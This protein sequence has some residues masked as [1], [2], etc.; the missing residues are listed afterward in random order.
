[1]TRS[2]HIVLKQHMIFIV[3]HFNRC[4]QIATFKTTFKYQSLILLIFLLIKR[5]NP[6]K[7]NQP[8]FLLR[9]SGTATTSQIGPAGSSLRVFEDASDIQQVFLHHLVL[10]RARLVIFIGEVECMSLVHDFTKGCLFVVSAVR[11][12]SEYALEGHSILE[13]YLL[14][15][16]FDFEFRSAI[17][18]TSEFK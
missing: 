7:V 8:L 4:C 11:G 2:I 16:L 6:L 13:V 5:I 14:D 1:M 12:R 15:S 9:L 3:T 17:I 18:F 10:F